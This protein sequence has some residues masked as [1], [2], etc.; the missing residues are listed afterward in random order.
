MSNLCITSIL[1]GRISHHSAGHFMARVFP[2]WKIGLPAPW[3]LK[4]RVLATLTANS[5]A[6][7]SPEDGSHRSCRAFIRHA[8]QIQRRHRS[9]PSSAGWRLKIQWPTPLAQALVTGFLN[10]SSN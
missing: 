8:S 3:S 6:I 9:N 7:Y 5:V 10:H 2:D 4:K 1:F